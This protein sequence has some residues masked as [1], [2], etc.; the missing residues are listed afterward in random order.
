MNLQWHIHLCLARLELQA[1]PTML[2]FSCG[3]ILMCVNSAFTCILHLYPLSKALQYTYPLHF[4]KIK[5]F[6]EGRWGEDQDYWLEWKSPNFLLR[7]SS[8]NYYFIWVALRFSTDSLRKTA[9]W[10]SDISMPSEW[11]M[12]HGGPFRAEWTILERNKGVAA[13]SAEF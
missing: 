2:A 7:R 8:D 10:A 11:P 3:D 6:Q 9:P 5:I 4:I 13:P 12:H 1:W